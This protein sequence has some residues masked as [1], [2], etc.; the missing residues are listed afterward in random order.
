[1]R[2]ISRG[3]LPPRSLS[4]IPRAQMRIQ[5]RENVKNVTIDRFG[6]ATVKRSCPFSHLPHPFP[7]H[8]AAFHQFYHT[9]SFPELDKK[10]RKYLNY[11]PKSPLRWESPA[12]KKFQDLFLITND[13][14]ATYSDFFRLFQTQFW[15]ENPQNSC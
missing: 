5:K 2:K 14:I 15:I 1:M 12:E 4:L 3:E 10:T 13:I 6:N 7:C 9:L 8:L 11:M